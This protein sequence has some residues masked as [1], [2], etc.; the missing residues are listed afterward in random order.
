MPNPHMSAPRSGSQPPAFPVA[1][2]AAVEAAHGSVKDLSYHPKPGPP[3][4]LRSFVGSGL[5]LTTTAFDDGRRLIKL[6][7]EGRQWATANG[8]QT[9][10]VLASDPAGEWILANWVQAQPA[11]GE[12]FVRAAIKTADMIMG[13]DL[14]KTTVAPSRW[15]GSNDDRTTRM[16][17]LLLGRL[18]ILAFRQAKAAAEQLTD[19]RTAHGDFYPRNALPTANSVAVI[20]WEFL[21][22]AP[23]YT[24]HLRLWST[25]HQRAD[26]QLALRLI[27]AD[28]NSTQWRHIC[29]LGRWLGLRL[30]A[31]NLSAPNPQRN[32]IDLAHARVVAREGKVLGAAADYA[33]HWESLPG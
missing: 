19:V 5:V 15:E 12:S 14:P 25:L 8:I 24:D 30:L 6:E 28:V 2:I 27:L 20:D 18:P 7:V 10:T 17:R 1:A 4:P 26:R 29:L 16:R 13:A 32:Q 33:G 9:A 3:R 31:E 11:D 21:A 23:A 22:A